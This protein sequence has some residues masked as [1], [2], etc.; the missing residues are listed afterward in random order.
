MSSIQEVFQNKKAF[1]PF[2]TAGDPNLSVTKEL[3][4]ELEKAGSDLIEIGIP[5]SDPVAEG[6]VIEKANERA[7]KAGTTTDK[8]FDMVLDFRK[9]SA[10]PL[11]FLT[12][13]NPVYVYGIEKFSKKCK[14]CDIRLVIVPDVPYEEKNELQSVF[15]KYDIHL[16]SLI[17]PTSENR[18]RQI[19][20]ESE[21]FV[22]C[23]SSLGVTGERE[24]ISNDVR[25]M[26]REVKQVKE[27]PCAV[28]FGISTPEQAK[29][30]AELSDGV[31]VGSAIVR[32]IEESGTDCVKKVGQFAR[33][34][35]EVI[36]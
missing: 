31:I 26:V 14:E 33:K 3:L 17:A 10:I 34:M 4:A 22:Y 20:R 29:Q 15:S 5:F 16:V 6:P 35:K 25:Y 27:I 11:V 30:M 12:Y 28:G 9:E 1:I 32:I 13:V 23:V 18:I 21:G 2:I 36:S 7:L 24:K 19:A 8:I